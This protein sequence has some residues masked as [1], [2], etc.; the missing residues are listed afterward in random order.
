MPGTVFILGDSINPTYSNVK[1]YVGVQWLTVRPALGSA[2][3]PDGGFNLTA[4]G[5][6]GQALYLDGHVQAIHSVA[7]L[8]DI[9][10]LEFLA[11]GTT[12]AKSYKKGFGAFKNG[13]FV[14][15]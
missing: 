15:Y 12:L 4:H 1:G 5:E 8:H 10:E 2:E 9:W 7:E 13:V 14:R 3:D 6:C 11:C